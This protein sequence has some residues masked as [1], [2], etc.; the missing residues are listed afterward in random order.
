[1]NNTIPYGY[2]IKNGVIVIDERQSKQVQDFF[3]IY[4]EGVGLLESRRHSG[5]NK[6]HSVMKRILMNE[7]YLVNEINPKIIDKNTFH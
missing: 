3:K 4:L 1:M 2:A 6:Q 7:V 5:I